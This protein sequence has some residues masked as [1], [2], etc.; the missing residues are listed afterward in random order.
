M[1]TIAFT[2]TLDE[3]DRTGGAEAITYGHT[4]LPHPAWDGKVFTAPKDGVYCFGISFMRQLIPMGAKDCESCD[5]SQIRLF[6]AG[7]DDGDGPGEL[8]AYAWV[9]ESKVPR[10]SGAVTV[11][12]KLE[13][14]DRVR[15]LDWIDGDKRRF[16]RHIVFTG[17]RIR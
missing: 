12:L 8:K 6:V 13:K 10:S 5:D 16:F 1:K 14:D 3:L 2:A 17:Y 7:E 15:T 4:L 11:C 9:G